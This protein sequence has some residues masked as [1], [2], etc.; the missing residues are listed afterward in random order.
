MILRH[1]N[2]ASLCICITFRELQY[3]HCEQSIE[4]FQRVC[5]FW[6]LWLKLPQAVRFLSKLYHQF[7]LL[8]KIELWKFLNDAWPLI[9]YI[10]VEPD[11]TKIIH[12]HCESRALFQNLLTVYRIGPILYPTHPREVL[13]HLQVWDYNSQTDVLH[14][15]A[16]R[17]LR[18][19]VIFGLQISILARCWEVLSLILRLD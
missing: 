13:S 11:L 5:G 19:L 16:L 17:D 15:P 1:H 3:L 9:L 18:L 8:L 6:R 12:L 4:M 10:L 2:D 14:K 7:L